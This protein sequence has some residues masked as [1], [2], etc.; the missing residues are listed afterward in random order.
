M[1]RRPVPSAVREFAVIVVGVLS[2]L[3]L[4]SAWQ[5]WQDSRLGSQYLEA[6][7][8]EIAQNMGVLEREAESAARIQAD[9]EDAVRTISA[10]DVDGRE[11]AVAGG[12]MQAAL[13]SG[14]FPQV[15]QVVLDDLKGTGALRLIDNANTRREVARAYA[16]MGAM[17]S[18]LELNSTRIDPQLLRLVS[19]H[20]L[21]R[22]E[23]SEDP[24][25]RRPIPP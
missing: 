13:L 15:S 20:G 2:A 24:R 21:R 19:D 22:A 4:E 7:V 16:T 6:V 5:N 9:L 3:G 18:R 8:E 1:D 11:Q 17:M 23:G 14:S 10:D 12:L 25:Q